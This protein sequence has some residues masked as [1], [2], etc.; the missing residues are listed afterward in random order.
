MTIP[1][2]SQPPPGTVGV[3]DFFVRG[4]DKCIWLGV[5][6]TFDAS[7]SLLVSDINGLM[8]ADTDNLNTAKA[9]ATAGLAG[10]ANTVHTHAISDVIGLQAALDGVANG[11]PTGCILIWHGAL[12]AIPGGW[13]LCDGQNG[14]P[15]LLDKFVFG[16]GGNANVGDTGGAVNGTG[17]TSN[18]GGFT[19]AGLIGG[20]TLTLAQLP[21]H[22]HAGGFTDVQGSHNHNVVGIGQV[23]QPGGIGSSPFVWTQAGAQ[24]YGTTTNGAHQH[25]VTVGT[26]GSNGSH[27]HTLTMSAVGGHTHSVTLP[28]MPPYLALG[29]IMKG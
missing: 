11:I 14:T 29:Y 17:T 4:A 2:G 26:E 10:K 6:L 13:L 12:N 23:N 27:T 24:V 25:N 18:A 20:T 22:N 1:S 15:N 21:A 8:Q 5:Q 19:P 7:G 28:T 9:F 3:G 16:A